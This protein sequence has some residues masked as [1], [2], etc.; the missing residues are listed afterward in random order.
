MDLFKLLEGIDNA[1]VGEA[2]IKAHS[3]IRSHRRIV[4]S[5]SGGSDSDVMLDMLERVKDGKEI[6]YVFFNTGVEYRATLDHLDF[7]EKKYGI[8]IE[9]VKPI[10]P[11][12][13]SCKENG[14]PFLNKYVSEMIKR[15][16]SKGFKWE[17]EPLEDLEKK[18]PKCKAALRWWTNSRPKESDGNT[19]RFSICRFRYLKEF[20]MQNPP[21][22]RISA[23]CCL[24]AKKKP[25]HNF[26][27]NYE[28]DLQC[29]GVRKAEG[30]I[31]ATT[32]KNCF[33]RNE[34]GVDQFRPIFWL[35]DND[36]KYYEDH[37]GVTHSDC[38]VKYGFNRTGC[39][40]CPF[41][42]DFEDNVKRTEIFEPKL[43]KAM[44]NIFGPSYEYKRKYYEYRDMRKRQEKQ[45]DGQL[46]WFD[47]QED[48]AEDIINGTEEE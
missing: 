25:A 2:L 27:D 32:Y 48:E 44:S 16:Q 6:K 13:V 19:S 34:D 29:V 18:Y 31:R 43:A 28:A 21:T 20:I 11:I 22:F 24:Y 8:Q 1:A 3:V 23:E 17:D 10:K 33:T 14:V 47:L 41:A 35:N 39:A 15:L 38:Y 40:G 5:I 37:F 42:L 12:P 9:R 46:N 4:A 7:L 26:L 45:T 36:K 30:G